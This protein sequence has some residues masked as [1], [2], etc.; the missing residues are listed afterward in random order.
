MHIL[1]FFILYHSMTQKRFERCFSFHCSRHCQ[2]RIEPVSKLTRKTFRYEL[3][4]EP[5]SP[6]VPVGCIFYCR[7][8][9]DTC[10]QPGIS[11]IINSCANKTSFWM[12]DFYLIDPRTVGT[13]TIE[14]IPSFNSQLF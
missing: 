11:N 7:I 6:I 10:I 1:S 8:G 9:N 2:E 14:L 3:R 12:P 4:W 13:V 5:L